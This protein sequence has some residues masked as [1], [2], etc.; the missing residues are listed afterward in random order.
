[1]SLMT[2]LESAA[3]K[4]VGGGVEEKVTCFKDHSLREYGSETRT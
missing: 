4:I 1:M 2:L 3:E